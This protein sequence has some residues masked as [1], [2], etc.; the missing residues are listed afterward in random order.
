MQRWQ[1]K[2]GRKRRKKQQRLKF[3][4]QFKYTSE[5]TRHCDCY[6]YVAIVG[7][8]CSVVWQTQNAMTIE[9]EVCAYTYL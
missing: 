7:V 2:K 5:D 9:T 1:K 6:K 8:E 4:L 3:K